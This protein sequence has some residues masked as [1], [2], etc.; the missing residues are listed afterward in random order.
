V[1]FQEYIF[2]RRYFA[3]GPNFYYCLA[4]TL[5][6]QFNIIG[7][8]DNLLVLASTSL[9]PSLA[10]PNQSRDSQGLLPFPLSRCRALIL[11]DSSISNVIRVY[12]PLHYVRSTSI[13][14]PEISVSTYAL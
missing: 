5:G 9:L 11:L 3:L 8:S 12:Y 6:I 14:R 7:L 13:V 10:C 4:E 1:V 2:G